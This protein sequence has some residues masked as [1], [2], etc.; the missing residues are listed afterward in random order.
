MK[1]KLL[2]SILF[3]GA[4][5]QS[6]AQ[7]VLPQVK[8]RPADYES[9]SAPDSLGI[10]HQLL[11]PNIE[12]RNTLA[13]QS[14]PYPIIFI[15]G[16]DSDCKVWGNT[17][18]TDLM[19]NSLLSYGLTYGGRFDFNL[20]DDNSNSTSNKL[21]YP[22]PGADISQWSTTLVNAD[23]YFLNFAVGSDGSFA[24]SNISPLN[25]LSNEAAI[26][27]QGVALSRAIQQVMNI[28]GRDKVVLMG[29]SMGGLCAR[30]YLQNPQNWTEPNI[31]HHV[32]KLI[33]TGT[34][35]GG[36]TGANFIATGINSSSEAYRDLRTD[37]S[38]S[39]RGV[40]LSGGIES[41]NNI[42]TSYF[43]N[44]INCNGINNDGSNIQGLNQKN[45]YN[46][47]DYAYIM[48]NCTN[49]VI[50]QGSILGDGVVR[51]VNANLSNFYNLPS[52]KNEFIY[53]ASAITEIHSD[54]PKQIYENMQ[55]LDEPNEFNLAYGID[56]GKTYKGFTTVQ[57]VGG[58]SN[59]YDIYKFSVQGNGNLTFTILN[60]F[61]NNLTVQFKNNIGQVQGQVYSIPNG[62][63]YFS[64]PISSGSGVYY[65]EIMGIP[66]TTSY[67]YPYTF[68]MSY[69]LSNQDF[70]LNDSLNLFPN[71]T[72][73]KV[74]FDNANSNFKEVAIY[75]YLGQE[76]FKTG[77]TSISNNQE[78]DMSGLLA[79]V[80]I[81]KFSNSETSQSVKVVK[82]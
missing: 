31:N 39:N 18:N 63:W 62:N 71:P 20:N 47:V 42:G 30:E 6:N 40:F 3:L 75:N 5:Y 79:G 41:T 45:L 35:H 4:F 64:I 7:N 80:Y 38:N 37:Y 12:N 13:N 21:F 8:P 32:A 16:L 49:C 77:F 23:Y 54:L 46:N 44:D 59:D 10:R 17:V 53:T 26:V 19:Y 2:L 22:T 11:M 76:V 33:T 67:L 14:L 58:Y 51:I 1:T 56:F 61:T 52:P 43:N 50:T 57:P 81:L 69:T 72:S 82:R 65:L 15:H 55:G 73:S 28:T 68:N 34:P 48:G 74:F 60:T 27:K 78:V 70:N 66:T 25:V 36:Y 24:P 29:H 9:L